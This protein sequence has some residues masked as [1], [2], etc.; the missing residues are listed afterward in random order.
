MPNFEVL[1]VMVHGFKEGSVRFKGPQGHKAVFRG[2]VG[3][4]WLEFQEGAY[5]A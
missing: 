1:L 3:K 5:C 4:Y 2:K